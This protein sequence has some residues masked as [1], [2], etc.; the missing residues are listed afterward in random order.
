MCALVALF[1]CFS[2]IAADKKPLN[3][4]QLKLAK[5]ARGV[6][7]EYCG[8]CH[9]SAGS[10][11]DEM[12]IDREW[13]VE[14]KLVF[15]FK[16]NESELYTIIEEKPMPPKKERNE[17]PAD[18]LDI[19]K[20]WIEAGAPPWPLKPTPPDPPITHE[21]M[22][23]WM[24]DDLMDPKMTKADR[25]D[26][27]YFTLTHLYN[28]GEPPDAMH[29]YRTALSKLINSLSRNPDITNPEPID[30]DNKTILRISLTKYGWDPNIWDTISIK[31]PYPYPYEIDHDYPEQDELQKET[32]A[33]PFIR[34][35]WFIAN[36]AKPKLYHEILQLPE[37]DLELEA[38]LKLKPSVANNIQAGVGRNFMRAGFL[39]SGVSRFNRIVER[40][41]A[42]NGAYWKS[43]DFSSN[44]KEQNIFR[45]PIGPNEY[46]PNGINKPAVELFAP[47]AFKQA[48]GEIIFSLE[49]KLQGYFLVDEK[50]NRLDEA[51]V[52]IVRNL[53]SDPG[54]EPVISNGL[55]CMTCHT[56]GIK[57]FDLRA[58]NLRLSIEKANANRVARN[59]DKEEALNTY[60]KAATINKQVKEDA[61]AFMKAVEE[62]GGVVGNREPI[63]LLATQYEGPL[64]KYLAAG[65]LGVTVQVLE[66]AI[67]EVS[68]LQEYGLHT[69]LVEDGPGLARESWEENY[70]II[71]DRVKGIGIAGPPAGGPNVIP[72]PLTLEASGNP[73]KIVNAN[74]SAISAMTWSPDPQGKT[75][76]STGFDAAQNP[77]ARPGQ[78]GALGGATILKWDAVSWEPRRGIPPVVEPRNLNININKLNANPASITTLEFSPAE[79][80]RLVVQSSSFFSIP[81]RGG[82]SRS[83]QNSNLRIFDLKALNKDPLEIT[84]KEIPDELALIKKRAEP[85]F[86]KD[87]SLR[88]KDA[89]E[90]QE[91]LNEFKISFLISHFAWSQD[92]KKLAVVGKK[93]VSQFPRNFP[94][95]LLSI[96]VIPSHNKPLVLIVNSVTG[97]EI[98]RRELRA[99]SLDWSPEGD[100]LGI[101]EGTILQIWDAQDGGRV[102][103]H[104]FQ[105][106]NEPLEQFDVRNGVRLDWAPKNALRKIQNK[107]DSNIAVAGVRGDFTI[108]RIGTRGNK[109]NGQKNIIFEQVRVDP[110]AAILTG[111]RERER[112][113]KR[114]EL[115]RLGAVVSLA[116]SS[117]GQ[118]LA[119]GAKQ[120]A[121]SPLA[122]DAV[123]GEIKIWDP[124][125]LELPNPKKLDQNQPIKTIPIDPIQVFF[126]RVK[127]FRST[128]VASLAWRPDGKHLAAGLD[129][130]TIRV[131]DKVK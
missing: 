92:G 16:P 83:G 85:L 17:V 13:L 121:L 104:A 94:A 78:G 81:Q 20:E 88:K 60:S 33:I 79:E 97:K 70:E 125:R 117:D 50:G 114:M 36:A 25:R 69:L 100:M 74:I 96:T 3:P 109:P 75:I 124:D 86:D 105:E 128:G 130:G 73:R 102:G 108:V 112:E 49:N 99:S 35:D 64:D 59:F 131:F 9:G 28:A 14:E 90:R 18:K 80:N 58:D 67:N 62:T 113:K 21:Q 47:P 119:T 45:F 6:L 120:R 103:R 40:H 93:I 12:L 57:A 46:W 127:G 87:P 37:T 118:R 2:A 56:R 107:F 65:E 23:K 72:F 41:A 82:G 68:E 4:A 84:L 115:L 22:L 1:F 54:N 116:W 27:R 39:E 34:A 106:A 61:A 38:E 31:S 63:A 91:F 42:P 98:A 126:N 101:M 30:E 55:S 48:G 52:D 53:S 15:P 44:K 95:Q 10:W 129:D 123:P 29:N 110:L 77:G 5:D 43:Y 76:I 8:K 11:N 7:G 66:K 89:R 24:R 111:A 26:T 32:S 51:P 122:N 71:Y 19:I